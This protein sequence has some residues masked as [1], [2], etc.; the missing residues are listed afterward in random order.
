MTARWRSLRPLQLWS[1]LAHGKK[2]KAT[3]A[4][5]SFTIVSEVVGICVGKRAVLQFFRVGVK[6]N[7][8][9]ASTSSP[10]VQ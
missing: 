7:I 5:K 6:G 4:A 1:K 9:R 10:P 3:N 8:S 2:E